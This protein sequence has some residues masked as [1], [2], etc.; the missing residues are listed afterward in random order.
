MTG[1]AASPELSV[2]RLIG[3]QVHDRDG[4]TIGRLSE[5]VARKDGDAL[6]VAH[7]LVGPRGWLH[8]F[9]VHG[10]GLRARRLASIY[11]VEWDQIDFTDPRRPRLT[12]AREDLKVETLPPR[13]RGLTRRPG[14][15]LA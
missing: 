8:R 11:K 2:E 5:V 4:R 9:A 3:R 10:L 1:R 7:Y 6:V 13:K 14:R 12:C 15:R